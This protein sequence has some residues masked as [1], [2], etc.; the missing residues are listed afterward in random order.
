MGKCRN[1]PGQHRLHCLPGLDSGRPRLVALP[2]DDVD[3][4][5]QAEALTVF[6]SE[7]PGHT[8]AVQVVDLGRNDGSAAPAVDPDVAGPALAKGL[9]EVFEELD[10]AALVGA[11]GDRVDVLLDGGDGHLVHRSVVTE[12]NH[13]GALGLQDPPHDVD[14]CVVPVEQ[15]G[16]SE[17]PD[18]S[19]GNVKA[20]GS[21]GGPP[22]VTRTSY[23]IRCR[24]KGEGRGRDT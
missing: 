5:R 3:H 2:Q 22:E 21:H 18:R 4:R 14:R 6:R 11:Q 1:V 17:H 15:R 16:R 8:D 24:R 23:Y 9:H 20:F 10:V 12:M 7:D 19:R 13:L